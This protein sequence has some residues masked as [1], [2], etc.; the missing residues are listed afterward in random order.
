MPRLKAMLAVASLSSFT[1]KAAK[2]RA[3]FAHE[4]IRRPLDD[5]KADVQDDWLFDAD[6]ERSAHSD[7]L[8]ALSASLGRLREAISRVSVESPIVVEAEPAVS[9]GQMSFDSDLFDGEPMMVHAH[10]ASPFDTL[11]FDEQAST[12]SYAGKADTQGLFRQAA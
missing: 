2:P 10:E 9:L 11:L 5:C 7:A 12:V 4:P 6:H 1:R 8:N 3:D